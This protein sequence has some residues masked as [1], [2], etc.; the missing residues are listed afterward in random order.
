MRC[1]VA[2]LAALF[3]LV[4]GIDSVRATVAVKV[5]GPMRVEVIPANLTIVIGD[6]QPMQ[7]F[8]ESF[9]GFQ[10]PQQHRLLTAT[11][12]SSNPGVATINSS[13]GL[14]TAVAK[15][16]TLIRAQSGPFR[17]TT[18]LTVTPKLNSITVTPA[19]QTIPQGTT[20]QFTATGNYADASTADLTGQVTWA[21]TDQ[22]IATIVPGGMATASS[23]NTGGAFIQAT[24]NSVMGQTDLTVGPAALVSI[25]VTPKNPSV[26]KGNPQ[27]FTATGTYTNSAQIDI[28]TSVTWGSSDMTKA[29][30]SNTGVASTL[31]EG[32]TTISAT[33]SGKTDSTVLTIGPA[34]VNQVQVSPH[35]AGTIPLGNTYQFMATA[36]YTDGSTLDVTSNGGTTWSSNNQGVATVS[37]GLVTSHSQ[38][39]N[40]QITASYSGFS[41]VGTTT[42]P[43]GA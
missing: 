21:S 27:Q 1:R 39:N 43:Y 3:M 4:A 32:Q 8:L 36:Y 16:V 10:Q 42:R 35:S 22:T 18:L 15:G 30:I 37:A 24:Y 12:T 28:T 2:M 9:R 41:D 38:G 11:W 31:A 26:A 13:T 17:G 5:I 25:S 40:V 29:T 7:A 14:V 23:N 20:L 6:T 19:G 33:L 34:V